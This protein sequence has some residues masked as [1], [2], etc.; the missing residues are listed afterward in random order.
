MAFA[1]GFRQIYGAVQKV[2]QDNGVK[3]NALDEAR[4]LASDTVTKALH[5]DGT[6][7]ARFNGIVFQNEDERDEFLII[8]DFLQQTNI[9]F[10]VPVL[11]FESQHPGLSVNREELAA[12]LGLS[13]EDS[14]PLLVQMVESQMRWVARKK[15]REQEE[16]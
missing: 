10:G 6:G 14:K 4:H 3:C 13:A 7:I 2:I 12:R 8:M 11:G 16:M 15:K 9:K 5:F 1:E